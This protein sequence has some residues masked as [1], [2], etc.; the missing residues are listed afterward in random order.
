MEPTDDTF[1]LVFEL[2][3]LDNSY[4]DVPL[5]LAA[6]LLSQEQELL[7]KIEGVTSVQELHAN[8]LSGRLAL[9]VPQPIRGSVRLVGCDEP[10]PTPGAMVVRGGATPLEAASAVLDLLEIFKVSGGAES[11][12][13]REG[14]EDSNQLGQ[15]R[16]PQAVR[17][18]LLDDRDQLIL[19][20]RGKSIG[21]SVA[22]VVIIAQVQST[23]PAV[24]AIYRQ[25][26]DNSEVRVEVV[27]IESV[28]E[29]QERSTSQFLRDLGVVPRD[30]DWFRATLG[31]PESP[32]SAV[33][34][35][36]PWDNLRPSPARAIDIANAGIPIAYSPYAHSLGVGTASSR[37]MYEQYVYNM[38]MQ[39]L[40]QAIF[41]VNDA[42]RQA[43]A[44]KCDMGDHNVVVTG[45][46]KMDRLISLRRGEREK[47]RT[48]LW[49]P[50]FAVGPGGL[51]TT[52]R[53]GDA[54]LSFFER[55]RELELIIR[56]HFRVFRDF[57]NTNHEASHFISRLRCAERWGN[58]SVDTSADY[59]AAFSSSDALM[60]DYSS[61]VAEYLQTD[62]PVLLLKNDVDAELDATTEFF[63]ELECAVQWPDVLDFIDECGNSS[64]RLVNLSRMVR[65]RHFS[66]QDGGASK[67]AAGVISNIALLGHVG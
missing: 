47:C 39:K 59:M 67:R 34:F 15:L 14:S 33:V 1:C 38:P 58:I 9:V 10:L 5:A 25:L 26:R 66:L 22:T 54:L 17:P 7:V 20:R 28:H 8:L 35:Y 40:A 13:P 57:P 12:T 50:H 27:A 19:S 52:L 31:D 44:S 41:V 45:S 42:Q 51:A 24:D 53:Y 43:F 61:L 21:N 63:R 32:L 29:L 23:W 36:D 2:P 62:R 48:F 11:S 18:R 37:Q 49:N 4:A 16:H 6:T 3:S 30:V 65:Q 46:P 60:S 55:R 64:S 56:P